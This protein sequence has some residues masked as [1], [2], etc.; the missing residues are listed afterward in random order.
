MGVYHWRLFY[1]RL[2]YRAW[3]YSLFLWVRISDLIT[4]SINHITYHGPMVF[5]NL[6]F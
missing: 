1:T 3:V 5:L 4:M 2:S 6:R